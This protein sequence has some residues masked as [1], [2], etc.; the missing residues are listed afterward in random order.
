[1]I[2]DIITK[3]KALSLE[4]NFSPHCYERAFSQLEILVV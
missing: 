1:M 4:D 3:D 2:V